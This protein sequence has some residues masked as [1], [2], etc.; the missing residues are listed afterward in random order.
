MIHTIFRF[1]KS[2]TIKTANM[3]LN[4]KLVCL[5]IFLSLLGNLFA[6]QPQIVTRINTQKL[7]I[8]YSET[9]RAQL[10]SVLDSNQI[11][12]A[13]NK[14][15]LFIKNNT[16]IKKVLSPVHI[17]A[18]DIS[19]RGNGVITSQSGLYQIKKFQIQTKPIK[20][21]IE[22]TKEGKVIWQVDMINDSIA[23]FVVTGTKALFYINIDNLVSN[24]YIIK[25]D[26]A[27]QFIGEK[28]SNTFV[29][30]LKSRYYFLMYD[31]QQ[32]SECLFIRADLKKEHLADEKIFSFGNLGQSADE[33]V[34]IRYDEETGLF[35]EMLF[36]DNDLILYKFEIKDYR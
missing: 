34:P 4:K 21:N 28:A 13:V 24:N 36:K 7:G 5:I 31:K 29:G 22:K 26:E 20:T 35:Y 8:Q 11:V 10:Y 3:R 25:D 17:F 12:L 27:S 6:Q 23:R 33:T 18:F 2:R 19:K 16:I 30:Q 14:T 15:L 32:K 9:D 1:I